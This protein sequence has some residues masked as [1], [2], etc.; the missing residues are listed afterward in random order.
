MSQIVVRHVG[1][2]VVVDIHGCL[3]FRAAES[4]FRPLMSELI[5]A[6]KHRIVVNCRGMSELDQVGMWIL[7]MCCTQARERGGNL[8]GCQ[9]PEKFPTEIEGKIREYME[10]KY[11]LH[12]YDTEEEAIASFKT[13]AGS[14]G[15]AP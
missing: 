3:T 15:G 10:S 1:D 6:G 9:F 5:E 4:E 14:S 2:V 11:Q 13:A 7:G 12:F 8:V